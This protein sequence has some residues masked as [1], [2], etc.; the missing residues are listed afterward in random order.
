[1]SG[2]KS[3]LNSRNEIKPSRTIARKNNNQLLAN[4]RVA[5]SVSS[6][7]DPIQFGS[8]L[9]DVID[10]MK[11][12]FEP[13]NI[14]VVPLGTKIQMIGALLTVRYYPEA[15]FVFTLPAHRRISSKGIGETSYMDVK[16]LVNDYERKIDTK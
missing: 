13:C 8:D 2:K 1:M 9:F 11:R 7:L 10:G 14:Y 15:Q 16:K 6:S 5:H 3:T 4:H 12:R